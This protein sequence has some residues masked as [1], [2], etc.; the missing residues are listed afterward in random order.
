MINARTVGSVFAI[1]FAAS[2]L[3]GFVP[4]PLVAPDGVFAVNIW[5]NLVHIVT[6]LVFGA[7]AYLGERAALGVTRGVSV[8]YI[9]VAVLGFLTP[10]EMLLGFIHVNQA[11]KWLHFS[12][13]IV[14]TFAGFFLLRSK[15]RLAEAG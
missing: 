14:I 10:G 8:F 2:G 15:S 5:H 9:I 11:D 6:G 1:A 3:V 13:A 4:N 12:L 7:G